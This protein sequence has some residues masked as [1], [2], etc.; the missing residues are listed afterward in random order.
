VKLAKMFVSAVTAGVFGSA[1]CAAPVPG[2]KQTE[3]A[4]QFIMKSLDGQEVDLARYEGQVVLIVNVASKCGYTRQYE[5]L[6]QLHEEYGPQGLAI[7]GFPCNQFLGQEPGSAEEIE[8][9]CRVN[10]GVTFDMFA[11]VEVNGENACDLYKFLTSL[12][13]QPKGAGKIGW[14][15]EKFILD[16]R[17]FVVGRFGAGTKPDDPE[18]VAIIERE[19]AAE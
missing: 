11:K 17:G 1:G 8:R 7:L 12:D 5:Q 19:L 14:N 4:L 3:S 13:T 6:Q 16:R 9:F 10:Y 2:V 15:F 18:I